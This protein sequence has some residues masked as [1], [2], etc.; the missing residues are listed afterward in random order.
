MPWEF[1]PGRSE[2]FRQMDRARRVWQQVTPCD[3]LSK[4]QFG[5]L[6]AIA[7]RAAAEPGAAV[8]M[9][10]LARTLCQSPSALSQRV[11][12]L[13]ALCYVERVP[14]PGDRRATGV[15]ATPEG[16][17]AM[18]EAHARFSGM[19][20]RALDLFGRDDLHTLLRLLGRLTDALEQASGAPEAPGEPGAPA[21]EDEPK[22]TPAP[23]A[24]SKTTPAPGDAASAGRGQKECDGTCC[25]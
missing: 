9:S 4:S 11:S 3:A 17:R 25:G 22:T 13:E 8:T 21:P 16:L 18:H 15:R 5:T 7:H 20:A 12:A 19:L 14:I 6:V 10:E 23:E 2:L 24:G 1:D